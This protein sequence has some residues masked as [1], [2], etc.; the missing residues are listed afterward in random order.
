MTND[1]VR[2]VA[3]HKHGEASSFTKKY[4]VTM[5]VYYEMSEDVRSVIERETNIKR[6]RRAWKLELI[7]S[8]NPLWKDLSDD[9]AGFP[10]KRE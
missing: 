8:F 6:W 10:L 1:L 3:A 2:R 4:G 5:L 7:E 9:I